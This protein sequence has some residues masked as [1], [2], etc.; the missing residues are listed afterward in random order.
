M[1]IGGR[2]SDRMPSDNSPDTVLN[3]I[4]ISRRMDLR[5]KDK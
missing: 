3:F 4:V 1:V 5:K 2:P